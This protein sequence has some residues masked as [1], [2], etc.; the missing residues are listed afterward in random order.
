M[1]TEYQ[2]ARVR[3]FT[4]VELLVVIAIIGIL[5]ALLLPAIQA[6]REA[7][8]RSQC[9]NN[10]RQI[11]LALSN[12]ESAKKSYPPGRL[13]CDA[14]SLYSDCQFD[15]LDHINR[16][17]MSGFVLILPQLEDQALYDQS[18]GEEQ[19]DAIWRQ[20]GKWKTVPARVAVVETRPQTFVCPSSTSEPVAENSED[21]ILLA[22]G[23][24]A[25]VHGRRGP[26][27]MPK[28]GV[29]LFLKTRNTGV[30]NYMRRI[31]SRQVTDGLSHT[32]FV[33]EVLQ[34][35]TVWNRNVWSVATRIVDS[36]RTTE[37]PL[38]TPPNSKDATYWFDGGSS[39]VYNGAFGSEHPGGGNFVFGDGH[40]EF[41]SESITD[42]IYQANATMACEDGIGS[43]SVDCQLPELF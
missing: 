5:V 36:L 21:G 39:D 1:Q 40:V 13:N 29:Q 20:N 7:A 28:G 26:S 41:V 3:G 11:G 10:L 32:M 35:H 42:S 24:Y 12:Y 30:F 33:G 19:D 23:T 16:S 14:G 8:R 6:A 4:L 34:A 43:G 9:T 37:N 31:P 27:W 25:F 18:G 22:T 17:S 15:R 38:N 2:Q